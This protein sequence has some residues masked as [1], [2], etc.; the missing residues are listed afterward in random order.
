MNERPPSMRF[1]GDSELEDFL[2]ATEEQKTD[3]IPELLKR[4]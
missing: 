4:L 3:S 1:I 2:N